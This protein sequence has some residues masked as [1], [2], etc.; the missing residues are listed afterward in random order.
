[1]KHERSRKSMHD[2]ITTCLEKALLPLRMDWQQRSPKSIPGFKPGLLWE[3]AVTLPVAPP[4][5]AK[6]K[7]LLTLSSR[8]YSS[9]LV[10]LLHLVQPQPADRQRVLQLPDLLLRRRQVQ[11]DHLQ[12]LRTL[13]LLSDPGDVIA[14]D[15]G[16]RRPQRG[17]WQPVA[18]D[19]HGQAG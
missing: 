6:L 12:V 2:F 14:D 9:G 4:P 8:I 17:Q 11:D 7:T 3:N 5:R 13:G 1:M 16:L 19:C 10:P 15:R 18:H